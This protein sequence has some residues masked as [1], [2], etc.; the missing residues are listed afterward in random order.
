MD[1]KRMLQGGRFYLAVLIAFAGIVAGATWPELPIKKALPEGTFLRMEIA[2]LKSKTA[3]FLLPVAAVLP[4][5]EEYLRERQNNF[6]RFL[7]IRR[8]REEYCRDKVLVTALSGV[9]VWTAAAVLSLLFFFLLFFAFEERWHWNWEPVPELLAV[10]G[11]GC[12]TACV[13]SSFSAVCALAGGTVYL[14]FGLPFI[15]FYAGVILRER[16]LEGL[17]CIDPSEWIRAEQDWGA[18]GRGLW[19]FLLL[20]T[21]ICAVAHR[22]L[23][24]WRLEEV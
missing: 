24:E 9:L 21:L 15:V 19:I 16:Y 7:S 11:R 8:G 5:G 23:L 18:D 20:L 22:L 6:L 13:L 1:L 3:L 10:L 17:Y 4:C 2:G 14:A 12:L